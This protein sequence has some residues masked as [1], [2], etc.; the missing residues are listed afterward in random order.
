MSLQVLLRSPNARA[1]TRGSEFAAGYDLYASEPIVI[2]ANGRGLVSTDISIAIPVN[3][4]ARI[5]PRSGLAVKNGI[6]TGAGVVDYDYRGEVKV[7]LFNHSTQDFLVNQGDRIAQMILEVITTPE[8][9][10]VQVL[11][12]TTRGANGFGSTGAN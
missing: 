2:P 6:S 4:Y 1:P 5:A 11:A 7:M 3:T 8:V 12:D 9:E 10:V